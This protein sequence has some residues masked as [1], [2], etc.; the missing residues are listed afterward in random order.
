MLAQNE[1]DPF[2]QNR[3]DPL[4]IDSCEELGQGFH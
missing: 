3:N 4:K 2:P 1:N